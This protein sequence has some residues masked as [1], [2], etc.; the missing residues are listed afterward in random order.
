MSF[1]RPTCYNTFV[2]DVL[3]SYGMI[4]ISLLVGEFVGKVYFKEHPEFTRKLIH[5]LGGVAAVSLPLFLSLDAIAILAVTCVPVMLVIRTKKFL[6]GLYE[7]DRKSWGEVLFPIGIGM[8]ALIAS[9]TEAYVFAVLVLT[10]SDT[11]AAYA[12]LSYAKSYIKI[13]NSQKSY[14]GSLVHFLSVLIICI[15]TALVSDSQ[16]VLLPINLCIIATIC[17]VTE[18]ISTRGLDNVTLPCIATISWN[19][20]S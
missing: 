9:S 11:A 12:G 20:L 10:F 5:M 8:S 1:T 13:W 16:T 6:G 14:I 15:A 4:A 7:V 2:F 18:L 19:I 17:T 3:I